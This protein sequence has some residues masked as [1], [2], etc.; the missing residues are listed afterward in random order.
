MSPE[1]TPYRGKGVVSSTSQ[2][3]AQ[4]DSEL[5]EREPGMPIG[6]R[7]GKR[8]NAKQPGQDTAV[9]TE[10]FEESANGEFEMIDEA[11]ANTQGARPGN[12]S[13]PSRLE[14]SNRDSN[15][16]RDPN[17]SKL[18]SQSQPSQR[19]GKRTPQD[20]N[21]ALEPEMLSGRRWG[22]SAPDASIGFERDVRVDVQQDRILIAEKFEIPLGQDSLQQTYEQFI[23]TLDKY[24][25][26]WGRPPQGFYWS[27]R[28]KFVVKPEA[29]LHYEQINAL[30]LKSGLSTTHEFTKDSNTIEYG[31]DPQF[32]KLRPKNARKSTEG[33]TR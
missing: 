12:G 22:H 21:R 30:M 29:T 8:G 5:T 10:A 4:F 6:Q 9:E 27:P 25:R 2:E 14:L 15:A 26:E 7:P 32:V 31:K 18:S 28:L 3:I 23:V 1:S 13:R 16:D 20:S 33:T 19:R 17:G 24:S 11:T